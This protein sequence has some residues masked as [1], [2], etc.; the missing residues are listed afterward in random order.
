MSS[1]ADNRKAD[2]AVH[3]WVA[4]VRNATYK[5]IATGTWFLCAGT[6][7]LLNTLDRLSWGVWIDLLRL[8]P[9]LL[10]S[11]GIRWTF[12][13]TPLHPLVLLGPLVVVAA[14]AYVVWGGLGQPGIPAPWSG[15]E[16]TMAISCPAGEGAQARLDLDF[17][18]GRVSFVSGKGD[19]TEGL[20]ASVRYV[21]DEPPHAC[22]GPALRLGRQG[23][24]T[25]FRFL[26]PLSLGAKRWEARLHAPQPLAIDAHL[27]AAA[28]NLDLRQYD[29]RSV[30]L[31]AVGSDVTVNLGAPAGRVGVDL[32][33]AFSRIR[34]IVPEGT[35]YTIA[36]NR[37]SNILTIDG[38]RAG[39]ARQ[40]TA[41]ACSGKKDAPRYAIDVDLP[42][43][44]VRVDAGPAR[45]SPQT[46]RP[47]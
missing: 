38:K 4:Q 1:P 26:S 13:R 22:A 27:A 34:L 8:W 35:C 9:L 28:A 5:R 14:T 3:P 46:E 41:L 2:P 29:I 40:V 6:V 15:T 42:L 17:D 18:A 24:S 31:H 16:K 39:R 47:Q 10:I 33:G 43:A 37:R 36:R 7:L 32:S 23:R 12:V 11:L 19:E 20:S 44:S 30:A 25:R 45:P 21:G